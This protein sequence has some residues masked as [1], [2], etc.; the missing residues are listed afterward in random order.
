MTWFYNLCHRS[1]HDYQNR[2]A[3][4]Y[5]MCLCSIFLLFWTAPILDA[6][7]A[8]TICPP[9][10]TLCQGIQG[11][12]CYWPEESYCKAGRLTPRCKGGMR[13]CKGS[14]GRG[15]YNPQTESCFNGIACERPERLCAGI[16]NA[17]CYNPQLAVC[18]RGA[19]CDPGEQLCDGSYGS[20][21][22]APKDGIC[23]NGM[24]CKA[25]E[26]LCI[27][28]TLAACKQKSYPCK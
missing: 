14:Y 1:F 2:T 27:V 18:Q 9:G 20:S 11:Q 26:R 23:F 8:S 5:H 13:P 24:V 7:A 22:Y 6:M 21:C 10:Q 25:N 4:L 3:C 17:Q 28:G 15:C 19:L 12:R 16:L